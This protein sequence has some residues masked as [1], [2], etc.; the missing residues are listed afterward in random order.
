MCIVIF[1]GLLGCQSSENTTKK[2]RHFDKESL[3]NDLNYLDDVLKRNHPGLYWH[4]EPTEIEQLKKRL[5]ESISDS[6]TEPNFLKLI[7]EYNSV[8][9]CVHTDIKPSKNYQL[10]LD[11]TKCY[12]PFGLIKI[13]NNYHVYRYL[14]YDSTLTQQPKIVSINGKPIEEIVEELLPRIP[15]DGKNDSRKYN[16]LQK[17]FNK[18]LAMFIFPGQTEY[19]LVV[20]TEAKERQTFNVKGV[21]KDFYITKWNVEY[22]TSRQPPISFTTAKD[23]KVGVLTIRS[24]RNDLMDKFGIDFRDYLTTVFDSLEK[25]Q[26]DKLIIDLRGN[27]GG[28]SEYGAQLIAFLSDTSFQYCQKMVLNSSELDSRLKYDIPETF[29]DFPK[30]V[31]CPYNEC[32]W[33]QHSVLGWRKPEQN[34]FKGKVVFLIDGGCVSTTSEVATV[35]HRLKLGSFVGEEVGGSYQG[36]SGG[37]L[38]FATLPN[39]GIQ[40]RIAVVKYVISEEDEFEGH[41]VIPKLLIKNSI[42]EMNKE[43]DILLEKAHLVIDKLE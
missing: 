39:T 40:V 36:D 38:G 21:D 42:N 22:G 13:D 2:F 3:I 27:G 24:F 30:G 1:I 17:Q 18:Y 4:T 16:V 15:A 14:S 35:A 37:V 26:I 7:S 5:Q 19:V 20:E 28:Y 43:G 33:A 10:Y 29:A 11:S 25:S 41:G 32:L 6:M 31:V 12:V 9:R 8:I 34:I 23:N